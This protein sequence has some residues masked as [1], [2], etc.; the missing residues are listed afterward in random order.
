MSEEEFNYQDRAERIMPDF[1]FWG[2]G[3]VIIRRDEYYR[4]RARIIAILKQLRRAKELRTS[5]E[6]KGMNDG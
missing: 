5:L 4:S 3:I 2:E 1:Y 6:K